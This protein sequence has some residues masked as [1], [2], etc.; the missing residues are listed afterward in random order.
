MPEYSS[1]DYAI[2]AGGQRLC[3]AVDRSS[4]E[5]RAV[6]L[7]QD[8]AELRSTQIVASGV[9]RAEIHALP[10]NRWV[11]FY[12]VGTA[13]YARVSEDEGDSWGA[14]ESMP[15]T[16]A[17][18]TP[19]RGVARFTAVYLPRAKLFALVYSKSVSGDPRHF[20]TALKRD[21]AGTWTQG[22]DSNLGTA[23]Q[24]LS[25]IG[26]LVPLRDGTIY[27]AGT[28]RFIGNF[29]WTT[30]PTFT[31]LTTVLRGARY[32]TPIRAVEHQSGVLLQV[33]VQFGGSSI[34]PPL[35]STGGWVSQVLWRSGANAW[36][37]RGDSAIGVPDPST[38]VPGTLNNYIALTPSTVYATA[39]E[40]AVGYTGSCGTIRAL[41]DGRLELLYHDRDGTLKFKRNAMTAYSLYPVNGTEDLAYWS[42]SRRD[43]WE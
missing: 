27:Y 17:S 28:E 2:N 12:N 8:A 34:V 32:Q 3:A 26:N 21:D 25:V 7:D 33:G 15:V 36:S 14:Q 30:T 24:T 29:G 42:T 31:D 6:S 16:L 40:R 10:D 1:L 19:S 4:G 22:V 43:T 18:F 39:G 38:S 5:L 37:A 13:F 11:V 41:R 35:T 9:E 20:L 23:I